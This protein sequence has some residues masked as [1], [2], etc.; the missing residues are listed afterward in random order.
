MS[1]WD[2][3]IDW[4]A[5]TDSPSMISDNHGFDITQGQVPQDDLDSLWYQDD[6]T[7]LPPRFQNTEENICTKSLDLGVLLDSVPQDKVTAFFFDA[8]GYIFP[9]EQSVSIPPSTFYYSHILTFYI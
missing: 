4:N 3:F 7:T 8:T 2:D 6:P 5:G 9:I 1:N